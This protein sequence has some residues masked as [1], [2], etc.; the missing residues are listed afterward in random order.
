LSEFS[1]ICLVNNVDQL[2]L[3]MNSIWIYI[4]YFMAVKHVFRIFTCVLP[5]YFLLNWAKKH[6]LRASLSNCYVKT[7]KMYKIIPQLMKYVSYR[8]IKINPA[9]M[10]KN[11]N[12]LYVLLT[13]KY[14]F[15]IISF[16]HLKCFN[17]LKKIHN[18]LHFHV[19]Y[20][21]KNLLTKVKLFFHIL[22][23][24]ILYNTGG[25]NALVRWRQ[26]DSAMTTM[27]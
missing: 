3:L 12:I 9:F 11:L 7:R 16:F 22:S 13:I 27:Q 14:F 1:S 17:F 5:S 20:L 24:K 18:L 2:D 19:C 6:N 10:G 15:N 23:Y 25:D 26:Y 8:S 4:E 21:Y